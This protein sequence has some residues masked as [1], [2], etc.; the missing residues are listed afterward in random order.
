MCLHFQSDGNAEKLMFRSFYDVQFAILC[1]VLC[2]K[3]NAHIVSC[4]QFHKFFIWWKKKK[5]GQKQTK[6]GEIKITRVFA[7]E[8]M[9]FS[10]FGCRT[11]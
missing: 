7:E 9:N 10:T 11:D 5:K 1:F 3:W 4:L 6:T 8:R 2:A